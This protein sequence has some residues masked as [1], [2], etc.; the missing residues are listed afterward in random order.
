MPGVPAV[1]TSPIDSVRLRA[2]AELL[3]AMGANEIFL[4]GSAARNELTSH[5]DV[6]IAVRGLPA[7]RFFAAASAA[8]DALNRPVDLVDLDDPSP[9]VRYLL[10]SGEL[11]RVL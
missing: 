1:A 5:S 11:V 4:F 2:A 10:S 7:A 8:T 9:G 6:D 3:R